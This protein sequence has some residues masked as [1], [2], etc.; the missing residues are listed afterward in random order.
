MKDITDTPH[1]VSSINKRFIQTMGLA[2]EEW[3]RWVQHLELVVI[4]FEEFT[5]SY[6]IKSYSDDT[7]NVTYRIPLLLSD[8]LQLT[9]R[10]S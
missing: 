3:S 1:T 10:I 9:I 4:L 6:T 8:V 2:I 5:S 7:F